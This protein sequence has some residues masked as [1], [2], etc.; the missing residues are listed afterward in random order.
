MHTIDQMYSVDSRM[1]RACI[2]AQ[3][4]CTPVDQ[5]Q[6]MQGPKIYTREICW[7]LDSYY[8]K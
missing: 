5:G 8:S 4:K 1:T 6:G 2:Q 3:I 7:F